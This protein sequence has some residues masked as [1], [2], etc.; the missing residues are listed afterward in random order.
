MLDERVADTLELAGAADDGAAA[1][2]P[3]RSET[4]DASFPNHSNHIR[5]RHPDHSVRHRRAHSVGAGPTGLT[6]AA[7]LAQQQLR[8]TVIDRQ[9]EGNNP[10]R[11]AVI[12]ARTLEVLEPLRVTPR[13]VARGLQAQRSTIRDRD[14]V[15]VPIDF[16]PLPTPYP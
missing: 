12:H 4:D 5:R 11:A 8:A 15:L 2:D 3:G 6:L 10:S 16:A 9:A 13:L 14:R 7:A 1:H